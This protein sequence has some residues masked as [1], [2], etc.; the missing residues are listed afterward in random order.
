MQHCVRQS[1]S[2]TL[3]SDSSVCHSYLWGSSWSQPTGGGF[4]CAFLFCFV[5]FMPFS[6][7][8]V[9]QA[10]LYRTQN[11]LMKMGRD[12]EEMPFLS[13]FRVRWTHLEMRVL[14]LI[15]FAASG[16]WLSFSFFPLRSGN[17]KDFVMEHEISMAGLATR[18]CRG[19]SPKCWIRPP[20][21][22]VGNP[23]SPLCCREHHRQA[24]QG[25]AGPFPW[26]CLAHVTHVSHHNMAPPLTKLSQALFAWVRFVLRNRK[27]LR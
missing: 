12:F 21:L 19:G 8:C 6:F 4:V 2:I 25:P 13:S 9:F 10:W 17:H 16:T 1:G 20:L 27:F 11:T 22:H 15:S 23:E 5:L 7:D 18:P 26:N 14:L 3:L 24:S